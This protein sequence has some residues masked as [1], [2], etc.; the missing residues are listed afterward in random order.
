MKFHFKTISLVCLILT[1]SV[2][3]KSFDYLDGH[4]IEQRQDLKLNKLR[5]VGIGLGLGLASYIIA[6][7]PTS[8]KVIN[9]GVFFVIGSGVSLGYDYYTRKQSMAEEMMEKQMS[10]LTE[11]FK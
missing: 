6:P 1:A 2:Q 8:N 10:D 3:A 5:A 7:R 4:F 11:A 9:L